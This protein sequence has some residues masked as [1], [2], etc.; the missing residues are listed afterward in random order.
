M[1]DQELNQN[2]KS[3]PSSCPV[4]HTKFQSRDNMN[5]NNN[6]KSS[7]MPN[8]SSL[9]WASPESLGTQDVSACPVH[10]PGSGDTSKDDGAEKCP[11]DPSTR[12]EWL[13]NMKQQGGSG[14][15]SNH[16]TMSYDIEEPKNNNNNATDGKS[17]SSNELPDEPTYK[18][19]VDLP[20]AREVSSIPR[21]GEDSNWVY[22]S[23]KQFFEAMQRK[24]WNPEAS[25][26]KTVVPIHNVVNERVWRLIQMWENG[27]GGDQCGGIQL[28]SFK[29]KSKKLTPRARWRLLWGYERP[30]DRHDWIV[31]RCGK[32]VEY[33]IDFYSGKQDPN[34][35][36]PA[37]FLDVR[38]KL[39]SFEGWRLRISKALGL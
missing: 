9:F 31:N 14:M 6:K 30:F 29:G 4:D 16:P 39:N 26:M 10:I 18:T 17:C 23:Q 3:A 33:V 32:D 27:Q 20:I 21:T 36:S 11:V 13:K 25:D 15:P 24:N 8:L 7:W 5:D 19:Q 38:P 35:K 12:D 22:P 2:S 28:T 1:S 37:F 34:S